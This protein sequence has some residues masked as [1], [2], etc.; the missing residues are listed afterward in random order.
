MGAES[1]IISFK[2]SPLDLA[3]KTEKARTS[4][5]FEALSWVLHPKGLAKVFNLGRSSLS[6][7]TVVP[8]NFNVAFIAFFSLAKVV[9]C[10]LL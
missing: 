1:L 3:L 2:F 7:A 9:F 10:R 6:K 4:T 5:R 8:N